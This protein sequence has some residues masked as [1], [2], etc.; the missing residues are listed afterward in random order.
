MAEFDKRGQWRQISV[1]DEKAKMAEIEAIG[2]DIMMSKIDNLMKSRLNLKLKKL[3]RG[4]ELLPG[5]MKMV[6]VFVAVKP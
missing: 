3:Q 4:D 6:K 5:V 2:T 1:E